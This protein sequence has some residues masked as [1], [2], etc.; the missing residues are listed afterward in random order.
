MNLWEKIGPF[1]PLKGPLRT[2]G[3]S[4]PYGISLLSPGAKPHPLP[5]SPLSVRDRGL[6]HSVRSTGPLTRHSVSAAILRHSFWHG[7]PLW[8]GIWILFKLA[9]ES[10]NPLAERMGRIVSEKTVWAGNKLIFDGGMDTNN[11]SPS[12]AGS[13]ARLLGGSL[14]ASTCIDRFGFGGG[15][16]EGAS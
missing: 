12:K 4:S 16:E 15:K 11:P 6:A 5:S 2:L 14:L 7:S 10:P 13:M 1:Q 9:N 8:L 3:G